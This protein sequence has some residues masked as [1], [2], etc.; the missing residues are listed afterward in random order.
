MGAFSSVQ[1]AIDNVIGNFLQRRLPDLGP[2]LAKNFLDRVRDDQ[3]LPL[4][5]AF[6]AEASYDGDLTSFGP[7]YLRAKQVRDMA[8]HSMN[9][10]GPVYSK[11]QAPSVAIASTVKTG[12]ACLIP[13][14]RAASSGSQP[15]VNGSASTSFEPVLQPTQK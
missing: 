4:F 9:I 10:S 15:T 8:G 13:F 14:C 7:I 1:F 5:K 6:A 3:R 12:A 11:G 2:A